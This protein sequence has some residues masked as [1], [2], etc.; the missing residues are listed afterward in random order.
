MNLAPLFSAPSVSME[1]AAPAFAP[2]VPPG[3]GHT[4]LS[5]SDADLW[6]ALREDDPRAFTALYERHSPTVYATTCRRLRELGFGHDASP[7][8]EDAT[9]EAFLHAWRR[10]ME[11]EVRTSLRPWLVATALK[12]ARNRI[13]A[14]MRQHRLATRLAT[15]GEVSGPP[16]DVLDVVSGQQL[17][18]RVWEFAAQL[19]A[20]EREVVAQCLLLD[21][22]IA[23]TARQL[24]IPAGTVK[25]RLHRARTH[26]RTALG[27]TWGLAFP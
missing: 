18:A 19:P 6:A 13:R 9:A 3:M 23:E 12:A 5:G 21:R 2:P 25:S 7:R 27:E 14:D 1:A 17:I 15:I 22:S 24:G 10:R 11:I 4:P 16:R 8:S 20:P 26:L